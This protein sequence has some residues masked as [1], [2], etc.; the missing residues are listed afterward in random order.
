[1]WFDINISIGIVTFK[2]A[3]Y[4]SSSVQFRSN[5]CAY[6]HPF[7]LIFRSTCFALETILMI[8]E[9]FLLVGS[10]MKFVINRIPTSY[11]DI[12]GAWIR[13]V[14]DTLASVDTI[15]TVSNILNIVEFLYVGM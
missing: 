11:V 3:Q 9:L 8:G 5:R 10:K 13:I 1:M 4:R 12:R 14:G 6:Y 2:S 7:G 15:R